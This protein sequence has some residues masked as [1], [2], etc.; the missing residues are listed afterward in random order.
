MNT[1]QILTVVAA[2][3][4][5][6][7]V[8]TIVGSGSLLTFPALLA[9]G[10]PPLVA[11]V[12][13][14]VGLVFGGVS[15]TLGYRRELAGQQRRVLGLALPA[16]AGALLGAALLLA[17]P[18]SVFHR[19][20]P[21]LVLLAVVLVIVQ[22]RLATFLERYRDRPGSSWALRTGIFLSAV[23]GGYFGAAMGVLM[24][25]LL[26]VFLRDDLQRINAVKNVLSTLINAMAA[27]VFVL[28]AHVAWAAAALIAASS[29]V[30]GLVGA[31]VGRRLPSG[32]LRVVIVVAGLVA[33]VKLLA[34]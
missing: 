1:F 32:V 25:S 15:G 11:N 28:G 24:I 17:L 31:A 29:V 33:V 19:V 21:A 20:V 6:G 26:A 12:S 8:N 14:T 2:G 34:S 30:G 9:A 23:Y 16:I 7:I 18:E 22:P 3:L 13:N 5:A 27:I 10:Y 4:G